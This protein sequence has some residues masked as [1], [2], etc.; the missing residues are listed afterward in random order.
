MPG[1]V[2]HLGAMVTCGHG[3]QATPMAPMPRVRVSGQPVATIAPLY[4]VA[5]CPFATPCVTAQWTVGSV[6]VK[7]MGQPVAIQTGVAVTAPNGVPLLASVAQ[8]R[9]SAT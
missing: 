2:L 9:V 5:A 8:A 3:G 1:F 7:A 4:S 6:R